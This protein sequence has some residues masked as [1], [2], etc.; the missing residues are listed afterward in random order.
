MRAAFHE[1]LDDLRGLLIVAAASVTSAIR[2]ANESLLDGDLDAAARVSEVAVEMRRSRGEAEQMIQ[3][4]IIRQQPVASDLRLALVGLHVVGD[5]E[6]MAALAEHIAK[7]ATLR[8]PV[9]AVPPEV[10]PV[11]RRMGEIA[12]ELAW[13]V[14]T[15]LELGDPEA[16]GRLDRDD[17]E[18]DDLHRD[19]F[20]ILF[21]TWEHGVKAA[22]D[23]ALIGRFYE[24]YADHAVNA[25]QQVV[26]LVTGQQPAG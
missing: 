17:D 19:M 14:T 11:V 21:S 2:W 7:I 16:A 25:G 5:L 12:A 13:K 10:A 3:Q 9:P 15:V 24:R 23:L 6:R 1:Q 8:H 22:V 20:E 18:M 4:L 26:F